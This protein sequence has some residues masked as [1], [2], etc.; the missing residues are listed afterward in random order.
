MSWSGYSYAKIKVV[1]TLFPFYDFTEQIGQNQVDVTL[2]LPPGVEAHSYSPTPKDIMKIRNA[3]LF[4]YTGKTMEP[5]VQDLLQGIKNKQLKIIDVSQGLELNEHDGHHHHEH[6]EQDPHI[7]LDP[8]KIIEIVNQISDAL[9]SE[10]PEAQALF[11]KNANKLI[12]A[13]EVLE[14]ETKALYA[15]CQKKPIIFAGHNIFSYYAKHYGL[16]FVNAYPNFSP[17]ARPTAKSL[18]RLIEIIKENQVKYIYHEA[19]IEPKIG[20]LLASET[21]TRLLMLHG[22]HNLSKV[23]WDQN[24]SY[25]SIMKDN[26]EKIILGLDRKQP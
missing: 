14:R 4:I 8:N 12:Q 5:W 6:L 9:S 16:E 15:T 22:A 13:L 24:K 26:R 3:D 21:G 17:N 1:T 20:R 25:I 10:N 19:Q 11:N 23:E 2:L 18:I 7:W